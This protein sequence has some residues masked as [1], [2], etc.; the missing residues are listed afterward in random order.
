ML[1][2]SLFQVVRPCSPALAKTIAAFAPLSKAISGANVDTSAAQAAAREMLVV[3]LYDIDKSASD[4]PTDPPSD[5]G[6]F[7]NIPGLGLKAAVGIPPPQVGSGVGFGF[8]QINADLGMLLT[9]Y[10]TATPTTDQV[11]T[12]MKAAVSRG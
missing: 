10:L 11:V 6:N 12:P 1:A 7:V 9:T 8:V 3:S 5:S 2:V 4:D